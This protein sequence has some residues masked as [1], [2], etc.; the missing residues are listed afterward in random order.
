MAG[1]RKPLTNLVN[2]LRAERLAALIEERKQALGL[3][4]DAIC[5]AVSGVDKN[6]RAMTG[7][8]A[9]IKGRNLPAPKARPAL[10]KAIRVPL[11]RLIEIMDWVPDEATA[12]PAG[13]PSTTLV[14]VA[15]SGRAMT[16]P[17]KVNGGA[18]PES[19][20]AGVGDDLLLFRLHRDG[21][22]TVQVN[23]R[24]EGSHG[25]AV[26]RMLLDTGLESTGP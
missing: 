20:G 26:L 12:A 15:R 19:A 13:P 1:V 9:Y 24:L 21:T 16:P 4:N 3:N 5:R 14:P 17:K 25:K 18:H 2:K 8:Y 11:A 23:A 10:A 6:D 22:S 7:A